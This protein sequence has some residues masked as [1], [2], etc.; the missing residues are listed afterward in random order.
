MK[1]TVRNLISACLIFGA[2]SVMTTG[3]FAADAAAGATLYASK[4]RACHGP[5][6]SGNKAIAS[7][8]KVEMKP[9][10]SASDAEIKTAVTSGT[11]KMKAVAGV[12]GADLDNLIAAIHAMK[13]M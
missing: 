5:D 11:G 1:T 3:A 13:K 7:A 4:C 12:A 10:S 2:A 8:M 9:L 6:G